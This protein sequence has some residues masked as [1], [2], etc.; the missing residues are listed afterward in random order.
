MKHIRRFALPGKADASVLAFTALS[1]IV[2]E[3][4]F[5]H[6]THGVGPQVPDQLFFVSQCMLALSGV[7]LLLNV[8]NREGRLTGVTRLS[9]ILFTVPV[10][11]YFFYVYVPS[12]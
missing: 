1:S 11:H 9:L 12:F 5:L 3:V 7:M 2:F 4:T 6:M 10:L 8:A